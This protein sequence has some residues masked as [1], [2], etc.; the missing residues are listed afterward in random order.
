MER[1]IEIFIK[2]VLEN[3]NSD[4]DIILDYLIESNIPYII[5][6]DIIVFTPTAF[7]RYIF[8]DSGIRFSDTYIT[9]KE[10]VEKSLSF[11][12]NKIFIL[13]Q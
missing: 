3:P 13:S 8:K 2:Y 5:A 6:H 7:N 1:Y 9:R 11:N 4:D 10:K 12:D